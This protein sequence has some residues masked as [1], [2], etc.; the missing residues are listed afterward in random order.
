MILKA[1]A[2]PRTCEFE[3]GLCCSCTL[4]AARRAKWAWLADTHI[5]ADP[6]AERNGVRPA[7]RL[8]RIAKE[9]EAANPG[10]VL[11]NGDLA[12]SRGDLGDYRLLRSILRPVMA[13][14][15]LVLGVGNHDH[16]GNLLE[17]LANR[18][19]QAP[20]KV[21]AIVEQP[22]YR[23]ILLDSQI[24]PGEIGGEVGVAQIGWLDN[25]LGTGTPLRTVLFVHHPGDST[26]EGCRDFD[27]LVRIAERCQSVQAI[28]TGH[29][30]EFSLGRVQGVHRV[31]LPATGFPFT[32]GTP[33]GWIEA[34]LSDEGLALRFH[35]SSGSTSHLLDWR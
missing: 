34:D 4:P 2:P 25:V 26:S 31:C 14:V 28:V 15:P 33:C 19:G 11:L 16:R 3:W 8:E 6:G 1:G 24:H 35:A 12:W 13:T 7:D 23:F 32:P 20:A 10:G 9:I 18:R 29:D 21:A 27:S 17:A 22:P 30:H 5:S